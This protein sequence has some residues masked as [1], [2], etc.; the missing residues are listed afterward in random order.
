MQF[1]FQTVKEIRQADVAITSSETIFTIYND[2]SEQI[3]RRQQIST[4]GIKFYTLYHYI[5]ANSL[6]LLKTLFYTCA[7]FN[8]P[9]HMYVFL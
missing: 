5:H 4:F 3:T 9:P 7:H 2:Q 1:A 8:K 6:S